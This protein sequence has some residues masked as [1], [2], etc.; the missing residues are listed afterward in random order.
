VSRALRAA[1][2]LAL[3]AATLVVGIAIGEALNDKPAPSGL[4]TFVRTLRPLPVTVTVTTS[5]S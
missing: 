1:L 2:L 4:Q 5:K 3:L